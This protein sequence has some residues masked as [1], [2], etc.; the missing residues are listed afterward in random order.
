MMPQTLPILARAPPARVCARARA[1]L[2]RAS[3]EKLSI[4]VVVGGGGSDGGE[5]RP[6]R[7]VARSLAP[8]AAPTAAA[9]LTSARARPPPPPPHTLSRARSSA[10]AAA[11]AA[12]AAA[13]AATTRW[14][15]SARGFCTRHIEPFVLSTTCRVFEELGIGEKTRARCLLHFASLD[16][17]SN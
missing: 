16:C 3:F 15:P 14:P 5:Q 1:A 17:H 11:T 8:V 9:S 10:M 4:F 13:A 7:V 6:R 2:G 12:A